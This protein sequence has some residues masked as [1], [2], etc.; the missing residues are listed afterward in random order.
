MWIGSR[1]TLQG[2]KQDSNVSTLGGAAVAG[3][4]ETVGVRAGITLP[5]LKSFFHSLSLGFDYKHYEQNVAAAGSITTATPISY[6]PF[7][8]LTPATWLGKGYPHGS[9]CRG[10]SS[11]P[12]HGQQRDQSSI[13]TASKP[14]GDYIY[15][16]GDLSH[17]HDLP[18]GFQALWP[19]AGPDRR[20][21]ARQREQFAGGGLSTVR[22]YLEGEVPGDNAI[23]GSIELRSPIMLGWV[24]D[25][26]GEWRI[27]GFADAGH[28]TLN[29]PLP[30]QDSNWNLAS[31]GA[32]SHLRLLDHFNGSID[33]GL[34]LISQIPHRRPRLAPDLPC[35]GR[36]LR[37]RLPLTHFTMTHRMRITHHSAKASF[38]K[39][40]V[41][42]L[43]WL[44]SS[45]PLR[46]TP[47]GI[48]SGRSARRSPST[49]PRP[50][51]QSRRRAGDGGGADP[52]ARRQLSIWRGAR[53]CQRPA[54]RGRRRQDA[55]PLS[56]REI[57]RPAERSLRL[58]EG[59]RPEGRRPG[60]LLALLRQCRART[61]SASRTRRRPTMPTPCSSITSPRRTQRPRIPRAMPTM[62]ETPGTVVDGSL[63]SSGLRLDRKEFR[64]DSQDRLARLDRRA[65]A[66][67]VRVDQARHSGRECRHFQP[68]RRCQCLPHRPRQRRSL[69]G[70]QWLG[71]AQHRRASRV[72]IPG[73]ISRWSPRLTEIKV[74]L[75]GESYATLAGKVPALNTQALLGRDGTPGATD[76]EGEP[77]FAGDLDELQISKVARPPALFKLASVTPGRR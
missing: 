22:G 3:K 49:R 50:A 68:P 53:R 18:G 38:L 72:R 6:Y 2:T 4:G 71:A 48:P 23:V 30:E 8:S 75:D 26:T 13:T 16:R 66:D 62:A 42:W 7:S 76:A 73:I 39:L 19:S 64:D 5:P 31:I 21:A 51:L 40:S 61:R 58:G 63:I 67:L 41:A 45:F 34:P 47:G 35:L 28:V 56:H 27:Y 1:L 9:Q 36:F 70:G 17:E 12:R 10:Q 37:P 33:A 25:K 77:G 65:G 32:G 52:A 44:S 29:D 24:S 20:R 15:F 11:F 69:C 14:D 74:Y 43:P 57:R 60:D 59:L 55:A 46:R 54:V